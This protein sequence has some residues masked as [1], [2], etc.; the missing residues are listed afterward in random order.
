MEPYSEPDTP[1]SE[2]TDAISPTTFTAVNDK[3][4]DARIAV[5]KDTA[6]PAADAKT[7][8]FSTPFFLNRVDSK[9]QG[10]NRLSDLKLA[11]NKHSVIT[12][13][14]PGRADQ[15]TVNTARESDK[16]RRRD[17]RQADFKPIVPSDQFAH[18]RSLV[19]QNNLSSSVWMEPSGAR[20]STTLMSMTTT[21]MSSMPSKSNGMALAPLHKLP[22]S[23]RQ[24]KSFRQYD[25]PL[26]RLEMKEAQ[27]ANDSTSSAPSKSTSLQSL[28][29]HSVESSHRKGKVNENTS[30]VT[31]TDTATSKEVPK[32]INS[33][34]MA[35]FEELL[36]I[37]SRHSSVNLCLKKSSKKSSERECASKNGETK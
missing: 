37:G 13:T 3:K 22:Q 23:P 7:S 35:N 15:S 12:A 5:P 21:R 4:I 16:T 27:Q 25:S 19:A 6:Y 14:T 30:T 20:N 31:A 10:V 2:K 26:R 28:L 1:I 24:V 33:G 29:N 17:V 8:Y 34:N 18:R 9:L 32:I 36:S 11:G